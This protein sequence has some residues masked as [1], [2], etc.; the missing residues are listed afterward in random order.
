MSGMVD[1]DAALRGTRTRRIIAFLIDGLIVLIGLKL[2]SVVLFLFGILTLGLGMPLLGLL[3]IVPLLYSWLSLLSGLS[4]TPGQAMLGLMVRRDADLGPPGGIAALVWIFGFYVSLALSGLPLLLALVTV[5][6]RTAH[7]L[8][9]GLVVIRAQALTRTPG[10]WNMQ[11]GGS[12][13][14]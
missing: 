9:S 5:H 14:A 8:V 2:L 3:P 6:K 4:A 7:D 1:P 11:A 10:F 13:Y 12:P